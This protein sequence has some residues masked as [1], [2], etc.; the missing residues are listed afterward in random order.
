MHLRSLITR[1]YGEGCR[2]G[3]P[4][5]RMDRNGCSRGSPPH[6]VLFPEVLAHGNADDRRDADSP[7]YLLRSFSHLPREYF[8]EERG[9]TPISSPLSL[10]PQR[11][12]RNRGGFPTIFRRSQQGKR[13]PTDSALRT[14]PADA[15]PRIS[16]S[17]QGPPHPR[18]VP[19]FHPPVGTRT[20]A[21]SSSSC[22]RPQR[23]GRA[24]SSVK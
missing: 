1:G 18:P 2:P 5:W 7:H 19:L 22:T 21:T 9:T 24:S 13:P 16:Q 20:T 23:S 14:S 11:R 6:P 8:W 3:P 12:N 10:I 15:G 17:P 4:A